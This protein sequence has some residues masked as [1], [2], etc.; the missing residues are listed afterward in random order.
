MAFLPTARGQE[1]ASG[2]EI[3]AAYYELAKEC[4]PDLAGEE[5][6]DMCILLNDAYETL[7]NKQARESYDYDL[8]LARLDDGYTGK[9]LSRWTKRHLQEG[10][11]RAV[12][13]DEPACIGCKQC[14]W[15]AAA[16]FRMEDEYG[17]SRVFAQWLNS[18]DDIQCAIDSCPVD[19][20]YW[21]DKDEL[22]ALEFVTRRMQKSS[23][24]ISMGQGEGGGQRGQD[25]FQA[26]AAFLKE[27]ERI[28][29]LRMK[30]R[31]QKREGEASEAERLRQAEAARN[32]RQRTQERWGRFWDSRWGEDSRRRWMVPPH[33]ALIKYVG[34]SEGG[35]ATAVLPTYK[36]EEAAETAAKIAAMHKA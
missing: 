34:M 19:C 20:I 8:M 1:D 4:H 5:G 25:P 6:H 2:K 16:T 11:R 29:R 18:Q 10:E 30:R 12:Y 9:P 23:V 33:R 27:R 28:V 36:T 13:V 32:I 21:V 31:E 26:A 35:S 14:V 7:K 22:P 24:G 17:R 15:A 3:K